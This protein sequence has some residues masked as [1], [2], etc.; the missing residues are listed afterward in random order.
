MIPGCEE[1]SDVTLVSKDGQKKCSYYNSGFCKYTKTGC[2]SI[3]PSKTCNM[4]NCSSKACPDRHPKFCKYGSECTYKTTGNCCYSHDKQP[5]DS[6]TNKR[7]TVNNLSKQLDSVF[8]IL[9][10]K[11]QEI[12]ILR[13]EFKAETNRLKSSIE[14]LESNKL[15]VDLIKSLSKKPTINMESKPEII[16]KI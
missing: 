15:D 4:K 1:L 12:K 6:D 10:L 16:N 7:E 5:F 3:H 2:R 9:R 14:A 11:E 8:E 13:I